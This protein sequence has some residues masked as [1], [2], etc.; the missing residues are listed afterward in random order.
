MHIRR[1]WHRV[2]FRWGIIRTGKHD[3]TRGGWSLTKNGHVV[4]WRVGTR[5]WLVM[6]LYRLAEWKAG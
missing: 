5:G 3:W 1:W 4:G 6:P 2:M